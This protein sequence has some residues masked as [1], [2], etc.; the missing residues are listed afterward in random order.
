MQANARLQTEFKILLK[1]KDLANFIAVPE[2]SNILE[3]HFCIF[4]LTDCPYEGGYYHGKLLFPRD[5]PFKPPGIMFL[6]PSGRF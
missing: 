3:W 2:E 6:T 4:G 1:R 5:F